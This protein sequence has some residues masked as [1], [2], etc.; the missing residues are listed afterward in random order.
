MNTEYSNFVQSLCK[1]GQSIIDT[2]TPYKAHLWHMGSAFLGEYL[3]L[4]LAWVNEDE[5]NEK[6]ELGD[7]LFYLTGIK[8]DLYIDLDNFKDPESYIDTILLA[9][10]IFDQIK[11]HTIY[12]KP[13]NVDLLNQ[14]VDQFIQQLTY[15]IG[16]DYVKAALIQNQAKLSK[17]YS[18]GKYTDKAAN[19]RLDKQ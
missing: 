18:E 4:Q 7:I 16:A 12:N 5:E 1:E 9:E 19:E 3:E 14:T 11:K 17:R 6:E 10:S 2:L 8:P 13:L 15:S